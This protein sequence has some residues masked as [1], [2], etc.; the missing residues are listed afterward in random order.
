MTGYRE[1]IAAALGLMITWS[2]ALTGGGTHLNNEG[3]MMG[4]LMTNPVQEIQLTTESSDEA[5]DFNTVS[6]QYA[7]LAGQVDEAIKMM[8]DP[9]ALTLIK[10]RQKAQEIADQTPLDLKTAEVLMN[11]ADHFGL[12]PSLI[13][14]IIET[15]SNFNPKEVGTHQ[16]RGLMQIIP[17]TERWLA[18]DMGKAIG[19]EYNPKKI[20]DPEYNIGLAAAYLAFLKGSYGDNFH[21]ILSEYNRGPYNLAKYYARN[22]TY[23]TGYSK[24]VLKLEAKYLAFND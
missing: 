22:G 19:L 7:E 17:G 23:S 20:F 2:A 16:D 24:K 18:K 4:S 1:A 9:E 3:R 15:E 8:D 10:L 6:R 11:Y 12:K 13:L 21:R 5:L 14:A